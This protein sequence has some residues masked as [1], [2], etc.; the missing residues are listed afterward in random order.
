MRAGSVQRC[1]GRC[2]ST[3][4]KIQKTDTWVL[5]RVNPKSVGVCVEWG[6]CATPHRA[7][8][9]ERGKKH[10]PSACCIRRR[11]SLMCCLYRH[12]MMDERAS[13]QRDTYCLIVS[14]SLTDRC[15][16][17]QIMQLY[18]QM[19]RNLEYI[20]RLRCLQH[21]Q[22]VLCHCPQSQIERAAGS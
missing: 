10:R 12:R 14:I 19:I 17:L 3:E 16:L 7:V 18:G 9:A 1:T 5:G 15:R 20:Y 6:Q 8:H 22:V 13:P 2:S 11:N 21:T 4:N